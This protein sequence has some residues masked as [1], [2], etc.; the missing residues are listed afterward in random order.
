MD[1]DGDFLSRGMPHDH[2]VQFYE[3]DDFLC[4]AVARFLVE[5]LEAGQPLLV[6]ATA[7]HRE[8]IRQRLAARGFEV[9]SL[10]CSGATTF[11]DASAMVSTFMVDSTV[12]ASLF[13][14]SLEETLAACR[15]ER[16]G[17]TVRVFGEMVDVLWREGRADAAL[18][19]EELWNEVAA[20]ES[21]SLLCGYSLGHFRDTAGARLFDDVCRQHSHAVP[22][23]RFANLTGEDARVVEIA[24]LEQRAQTLAAEIAHRRELETALRRMLADREHAEIERGR[25]LAQTQRAREDAEAASRLKDEFL[26]VMSHE[27]RTP[28]NAILGWSQIVNRPNN[29]AATIRRGLDVIQKNARLQLH[30]IDDLLDMSRI[31]TGKMI[32][33]MA[34][35]DLNEVLTEA[36]E[37]IRPGVTAKG[38]TLDLHLDGKAR[39]MTGDRNRLQQIVWNL[40]SNAVKFTPANG[41]IELGLERAGAHAQ[42]VV[43]DNG[44]GIAAAFLPHVFDRFRQADTGTTRTY[45]G[46]GVGLAVVR[47]L[48]EAHGGTIL[49]SSDGEGAGATFTV[50]LPVR[51]AP[52]TTVEPPAA[53]H[54]A[55]LQQT[56]ALVVDDDPDSRDLFDAAL[57]FAGASVQVAQSVDE[58][59]RVLET[60]PIDVLIADIGMPD[61]DGYALIEAVRRHADAAARN[62]RAIAVTS[63]AGDAYRD[64]AM[65]AG[66]D[67]YVAKPVDPARLA[68]L[69]ADLLAAKPSRAQA[70]NVPSR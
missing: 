21:F 10:G 58:A 30:V 12:D 36:V 51:P 55:D 43:R 40:L 62:I 39:Y 13:K 19:L 23:E 49:A 18:R 11:V 8:D 48:V 15:Q 52:S 25:L 26:A 20:E 54:A 31:I 67:G 63:Y 45:G 14:R 5:G 61:R 4:E 37:T 17:A 6:V 24:R 46:L 3:S 33:R 53:G 57:S 44:L 65:S 32:L 27:L 47:H 69:V 28:L 16:D 50:R 70:V 64:R 7:P 42:I 38:I 66:Y 2:V 68:L 22:T 35:V 56:R 60:E 1:K 59:L 29:D 9:S 41:R 34:P